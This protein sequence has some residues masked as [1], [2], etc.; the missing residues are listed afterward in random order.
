[1]YTIYVLNDADLDQFREE[2]SWLNFPPT[3]CQVSVYLGDLGD[4]ARVE[5]CTRGAQ[6]ELLEY[7]IDALGGRTMLGLLRFAPRGTKLTDDCPEEVL[8]RELLERL[9]IADGSKSLQDVNLERR[10]LLDKAYARILEI[11]DEKFCEAIQESDSA[12][13]KNRLER[14]RQSLPASI[15]EVKDAHRGLFVEIDL[16]RLVAIVR[17]EYSLPADYDPVVIDPDSKVPKS[18]ASALEVA[19]QADPIIEA[20]FDLSPV[21]FSISTIGEKRSRYVR[22]N[23]KYLELIGKNWDELAGSEMVSSGVV[24]DSD[25]GRAE[26]LAMLDSE[27]GYSGK[28][29]Q[30]RNARGEIIPVIISARR[31]FL[32]G[33]FYDFE[34]LVPEKE[35]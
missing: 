19:T 22:V 28:K 17:D 18:R 24:V 10:S 33:Q 27:G 21:A 5:A 7:D 25:D 6:G 8:V 4:V 26:R 14:I 30:I 1:M 16:W 9:P 32:S 29:A 13:E 31:L 20:I 34:V 15:A 12:V 3:V 11:A 35:T 2:F 23:R